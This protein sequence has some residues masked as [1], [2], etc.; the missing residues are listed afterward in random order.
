[1]GNHN[2]FLISIF[3]IITLYN[4]L[5]DILVNG[6]LYI[7]NQLQ[8]DIIN[9]D[10]LTCNGNSVELN[11]LNFLGSTCIIG[12][13]QVQ[14]NI[15]INN[16]PPGTENNNF[17][18]INSNNNLLYIGNTKSP[19]PGPSNVD[20]QNI[21][22]PLIIA[23]GQN[24][25]IN[26]ISGETM[27]KGPNVTLSGNTIIFFGELASPTNQLIFDCQLEINS[28]AIVKNITTNIIIFNSNI[29]NFNTNSINFLEPMKI[30]GS[31]INIQN[32]N[33]NII[34][35]S[36]PVFIGSNQDQINIGNQNNPIQKI[37]NINNTTETDLI[38]SY[39]ILNDTMKLYQNNLIQKT[40]TYP[41]NTISTPN[42]LTLS[43]IGLYS[44][45]AIQ[46]IGINEIQNYCDTLAVDSIKINSNFYSN[47]SLSVPIFFKI[48]NFILN[49]GSNSTGA[50]NFLETANKTFI[51]NIMSND[52]IDITFSNNKSITLPNLDIYSEV[53]PNS[54]TLTIPN[55]NIISIESFLPTKKNI[56]NEMKKIKSSLHKIEE[57]Q[58][59]LKNQLIKSKNQNT[60]LTKI[61]QELENIIM[62]LKNEQ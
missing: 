55:N 53:R 25:N 36:G 58:K 62:E 29:K 57:N 3:F 54:Y 34:N 20:I 22:T 21:E 38:Y 49:T 18:M 45:A 16:V 40:I 2:Y 44:N 32:N 27:L 10:T 47:T 52:T 46:L 51:N 15:T 30:T 60:F 19:I 24:I 33:N 61:Q 31:T 35:C 48:E 13:D 17:L 11:N 50:I 14:T 5:P 7:V 23:N 39:L 8:S 43:S 12:N 41:N 1:M 28:P 59:L 6:N 9:T 42:N 4:S 26:T 56:N 37:T